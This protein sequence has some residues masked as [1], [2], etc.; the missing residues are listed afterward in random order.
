MRAER[1]ARLSAEMQRR[2]VELYSI[3][4]VAEVEGFVATDR[5]FV[6]AMEGS[7]HRP[8]SEKLLVVQAP[9]ELSVSL[10]LDAEMLERLDEAGGL[11]LLTHE[12]V[13]DFWDVAEGVSHFTLLAWSA[14]HDRAVSALELE[15]QAEVDKFVL[16]ALAA[17]GE[18]P[19]Q[20]LAP[21]HRLLFERAQLDPALADEERTRY[22]IA[23]RYAGR[24]CRAL[25][26]RLAVRR[27]DEVRAELRRFYRLSRGDKFHRIAALGQRP[28]A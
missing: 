19:Q 24:Y 6:E 11:D 18:R 27:A 17:R 21:L 2:L 10:Y 15:L 26:A 28:G 1:A 8:A 4:E 13:A 3:D 5:A 25:S 23:S 14:A 20:V 22:A 7:R 9:G 12:T 16:A